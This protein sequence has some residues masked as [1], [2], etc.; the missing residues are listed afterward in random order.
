MAPE[1][2]PGSPDVD[3][4]EPPIDLT[5]VV[6]SGV[7]WK[8]LT[9][10]VS[11]ATRAIVVVVLAHLLTPAEYGIAGMA[12]V[13]TSLGLL[14]TDPALGAALIQRPGSTS[15]T[16]Q[17]CSGPPRDRCAA[18]GAGIAAPA[19]VADFFGEEQVRILRCLL[20]VLR[21]GLGCRW[22][23]GAPRP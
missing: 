10:V 9:R 3:L 18:D 17:P 20:P 22:R 7:R 5:G 4:G 23:I 19:S 15:A 11:D 14:F 2:I 8:S 12:F 21:R 6:V 16:G 1:S 13:V